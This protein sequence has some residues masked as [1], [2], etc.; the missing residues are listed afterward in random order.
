MPKNIKLHKYPQRY[1]QQILNTRPR[2]RSEVYA[3]LR[4]GEDE[5]SSLSRSALTSFLKR[6]LISTGWVAD[7]DIL[8][9][10][11][12]HPVHID[13]LKA[14][15]AV[16]I[17]VGHPGAIGSTLLNLELA[18]ARGQ[19]R[20]DIAIYV[21]TTSCFEK[22]MHEISGDEWKG[23]VTFENVVDYLPKVEHVI[24]VPI[25]VMGL[26][27]RSSDEMTL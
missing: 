7:V 9:G 20:I 27:L 24:Q 18:S 19:D 4:I 12:S 3:A 8:E 15:V 10:D 1:A 17:G 2:I 11:S 23:G 16:E 22:K 13:F 26:H 5:I 14:R 6:R 25:L 21:V